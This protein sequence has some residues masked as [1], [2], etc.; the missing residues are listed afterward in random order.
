M[1]ATDARSVVLLHG[2]AMAPSVWDELITAL[3]AGWAVSRP[4]LPGH[5]GSG[6][7]PVREDIDG[8]A[9]ALA[10]ALADD[11]I[12]IGWSLGAMLALALAERHPAKVGRLVLFGAT[13][14]FVTGDG[15]QHGLPADTVQAFI[16]GFAAAPLPTLRRFAT[17]Q[18]QGD[19]RRKTVFVRLLATLAADEAALADPACGAGLRT[20]L[21][22]LAATDLRARVRAVGQPTL[23]L[24]GDGDALMPPAAAAWLADALPQARLERCAGCGH[25]PFLADPQGMAAHIGR[26]VHD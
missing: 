25:A 6:L 15:W 17:L 5:P 2:W 14:R 26:F 1:A 11:A 16:D 13:P 8:W 7:R 9:D 21:Q 22:V 12:V 4:V 19:A 3:P 20:A 24:H 23:L 18:T 10:P